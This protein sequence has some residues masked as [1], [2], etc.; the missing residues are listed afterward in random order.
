MSDEPIT[1]DDVVAAVQQLAEE[2][3]KLKRKVAKAK[4]RC[5]KQHGDHECI[6]FRVV[7]D[8]DDPEVPEEF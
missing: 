1:L 2:V 7:Q 5:K 6:G 3:G 4:R 8:E